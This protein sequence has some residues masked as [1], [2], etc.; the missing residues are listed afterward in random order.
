MN[1]FLSFARISGSPAYNA[2]AGKTPGSA[3]FNQAWKGL[4]SSDPQGFEN[5]QHQFIKSSHYDPAVQQVANSIGLN[6]EN[7]SKAVQDVL[8]STSVQHGAAGAAKIFR[9][10][11]GS[12]ANLSDAEIIKRVYAERSADGGNKYFPS[13]SASVRNSVVNRFGNE[14]RDALSM[15]S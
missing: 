15:L 5:L 7:R 9:N 4:A 13:S 11:V 12:N 8:W 14:L 10:A 6:V 1:N 3:A 2:L